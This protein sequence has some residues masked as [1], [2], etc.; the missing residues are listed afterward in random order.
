MHLSIFAAATVAL[1]IAIGGFLVGDGLVAMKRADR[2][3]SVKGLSEREVESNLALWSIPYSAT[4]DDLVQTQIQLN[5]NRDKII[6]F[7]TDKGITQDEI[8]PGALRVTDKLANQYNSNANTGQRYILNASLKVRSADVKKV[9]AVSGHVG[10]LVGSGI[11]LGSSDSY[12]CDLKLLFTDLNRIKPEMIAE[13]TRDARGAA[14]QFAKD[15]G[16]RVGDIRSASQGYFSISSR[17]GG[18]G[19]S[20]G[21][22]EAETSLVKKARVVINISYALD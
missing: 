1:G 10:E 5:A 14:E 16:A 6:T 19:G 4:G 13:A 21:N 8:S 9:I 3:V 2:A 12:Q 11:V 18:D 7:L 20:E 22:C 17:D 15:S